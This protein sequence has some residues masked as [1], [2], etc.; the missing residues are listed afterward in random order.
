[1]R[2]IVFVALAIA[3]AS[4]APADEAGRQR[5]MAARDATLEVAVNPA[6]FAG[7][8]FEGLCPIDSID[9]TTM[10]CLAM[11]KSGKIVGSA[12][13]ML[14]DLPS[15]QSVYLLNECSRDSVFEIPTNDNCVVYFKGRVD[16]SGIVFATSTEKMT[17][18][19]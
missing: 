2:R 4:P 13:V 9:T 19:E 10:S 18:L 14:L 12:V 15:R 7:R 3:I 5:M 16:R 17:D 11:N 6:E 1:M 8:T